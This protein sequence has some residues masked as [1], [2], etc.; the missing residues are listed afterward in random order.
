MNETAI[1]VLRIEIM[2]LDVQ[3][4][5]TLL[6]RIPPELNESHVSEV[7]QLC[8]PRGVRVLVAPRDVEFSVIASV[9]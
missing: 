7:T 5:E 1:E 3:P 4:G 2:R 6:I 8:V 9:E